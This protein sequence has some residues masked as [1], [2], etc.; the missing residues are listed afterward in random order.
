MRCRIPISID[1]RAPLLEASVVI[2]DALRLDLPCGAGSEPKRFELDIRN[3]SGYNGMVC[4]K[5]FG[6]AGSVEG[7]MSGIRYTQG[8]GS[9]A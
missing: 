3:V 5:R 4:P 6:L 2:P 9:Q 8:P 7:E 1:S